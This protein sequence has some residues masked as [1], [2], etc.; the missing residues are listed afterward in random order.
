MEGRE[1]C[2]VHMV[3]RIRPHFFLLVCL[4]LLFFTR[5]IQSPTRPDKAP[6]RTRRETK[7]HPRPIP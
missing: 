2:I 4:F 6:A 7:T 1:F 3:Y 5:G